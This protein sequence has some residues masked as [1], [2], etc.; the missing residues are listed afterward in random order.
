LDRIYAPPPES[1][2]K[3]HIIVTIISQNSASGRS[4]HGCLSKKAGISEGYGVTCQFD[5]I[6]MI[7]TPPA[8]A[9]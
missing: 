4:F 1:S 8:S 5:R 2:K 6:V 3:I 9:L 7:V